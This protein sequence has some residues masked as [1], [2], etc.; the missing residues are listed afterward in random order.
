MSSLHDHQPGGDLIFPGELEGTV[1]R[2]REVTL[3]NPD[4]D[5]K[6]DPPDT[7]DGSPKFGNWLEVDAEGKENKQLMAA[8]GELIGELQRLQADEGDVFE[9]TRAEKSGPK[10]SDPYEVNLEELEEDQERL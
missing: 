4:D 3:Y 10:Q 7:V 6:P 9:V 8:P 1:F 5:E 2:L